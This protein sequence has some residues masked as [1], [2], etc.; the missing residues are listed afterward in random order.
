[1][2]TGFEPVDILQGIYMCVAQLEKTQYEVQN[3][4]SRVVKRAG[5]TTAQQ[6]MNEIFEVAPQKWRGMDE[7]ANSGLVLRAK[8]Q[9][10]DALQ[11][12]NVQKNTNVQ[13]TPCI[14][15]EILRGVKKPCDCPLFAKECSPE[16]PLGAT[17]VSSEGACAAYYQYR[18]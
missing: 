17:M 9:K 8:Y 16:K 7:I 14:S 15:G 11:R 10:F 2:V 12:F 3:Q 13:S 4:Y 6:L 5:N 18:Q 1:M